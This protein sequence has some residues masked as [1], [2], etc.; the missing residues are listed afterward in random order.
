MKHPI[1]GGGMDCPF[2]GNSEIKV[3]EKRETNEAIRRR[4]ECLKCN[5]RFTTYE[6]IEKTNLIVVKKDGRKEQF[7]REK[8][9]KGLL[10]ASEKTSIK[11]E[12][13][14]KLINEIE[15]KISYKKT[16]ISTKEIGEIVMEKLKEKDNVAYIRYASVYKSFADI[17]SF[18]KELKELLR[19]KYGKNKKA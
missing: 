18:E 2:C 13:L 6:R 3:L 5:G 14:D 7:C 17:D 12:D 10:K 9:K 1:C 4:R 15:V 8:L 11:E 19:W 16:E